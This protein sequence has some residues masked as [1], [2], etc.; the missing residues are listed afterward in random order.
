MRS[1]LQSSSRSGYATTVT[2]PPSMTEHSTLRRP[3]SNDSVAWTAL[4]RAARRASGARRPSGEH[5]LPKTQ[6]MTSLDALC[7]TIRRVVD[8]G[9]PRVAAEVAAVPLRRLLEMLRTAYLDEVQNA[10]AEDGLEIVQVL[11]AIERVQAWLDADAGQQLATRFEG[12]D[13]LN[14]VIEVAHDMRSPLASIL[15]LMETLRKGHSGPITT[16]Q[17]RQLGLAYSAAFG[18]NAMVSDVIELARGGERLMDLHPVPFS[19]SEIMQA[20]VD[21]VQ[22]IAEEKR[23]AI[24][25]EKPEGDFRLGHPLALSRVLLNL[26]TNALKFTSEGEVAIIAHEVGRSRVEFMVCDTG[27]GIPREVMATLF[28]SFRQRDGQSVGSYTFSSA[29][30]GLSICRKL[31]SAMDSQLRVETECGKGTCFRFE[32]ELPTATRL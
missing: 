6:A 7:D 17:D 22:P 30:L 2:V 31:I 19:V 21:I 15:F 26:T 9:K 25:I 14:S 5:G 12:A 16:L 11:G 29:G 13:A 10:H 8:G 23:L 27:R 20:V 3:V 4:L 24:R 1:E 32:L 18:L 28:D